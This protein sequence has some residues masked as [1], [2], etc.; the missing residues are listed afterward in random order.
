MTKAIG[1]L[2]QSGKC[3]IE[4][5]PIHDRRDRFVPEGTQLV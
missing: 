2:N 3:A 1:D 5:M 4:V